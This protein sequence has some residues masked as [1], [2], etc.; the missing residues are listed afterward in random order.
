MHLETGVIGV[1]AD[2]L[3]F[4]KVSMI[5]W[6]PFVGHKPIKYAVCCANLRWRPAFDGTAQRVADGAADQ[7][8]IDLGKEA[9]FGQVWTWR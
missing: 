6:F 8:A 4:A 2:A 3:A 1:D 9:A 7:T 5:A